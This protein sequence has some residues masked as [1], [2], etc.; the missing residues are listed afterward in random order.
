MWDFWLADDGLTYHLFF[1]TAGRHLGDPELRH[2]NASIGH[3][4]SA[5]L[6]VWTVLEGALAPSEPPAFDDLAT[7][8][9]SVLR[10]DDGEWQMFYTGISKA[11]RGG[12]QRFGQASSRDLAHWRKQPGSL[13]L[14]SDPRWYRQSNAGAAWRD[15][16]VLPAPG[17]AGFHMLLTA[18]SRQGPDD[19]RG[20]I[21]H[22]WSPDLLRWQVRPPLSAP[23][24]G[25]GH[26]EVPQAEVVDGRA[27]LI[28]SCLSAE[29]SDARRAAGETGGIWCVPCDSVTG[30]F[31]VSQAVRLT[32]ESLYSGRLIRDRTGAWR[33]LAFR[34]TGPDGVFA[35]ELADPAAVRWNLAGSALEVVP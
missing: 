22:A 16:W 21:G 13:V 15:P 5:D 3:A 25:F 1:L 20:V 30:P 11:E 23:G 24:T 8:T 26:L 6:R 32:D 19:Q 33:L 2:R 9:G 10:R 14:E 7:W 31:D 29:L 18:Q 4:V 17:G 35:G 27:V 34:N 28:F 12:R